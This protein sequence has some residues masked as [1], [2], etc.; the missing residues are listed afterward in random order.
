[1]ATVLADGQ[2][3]LDGAVLFG[4]G[5]AVRVQQVS[6]D[7]GSVA[8][9]DAAVV[10][11]DGIRMGVDTLPLLSLT[12]T[13]V[14]LAGAGNGGAALD[15]YETL[16]AAWM[17]EA[18]RAAPGAYSTLRIRY[19]GSAGV[20][21]VFGRGRRIAP[22]MGMVRQGVVPFTAQF[23]CAS[24]YFYQDGDSALILTM[25]PSDIAGVAN[26]HNRLANATF[27]TAVTG[28]QAV[29]CA[30]AWDGAT[31]RT[32][33]GA[34]RITPAG[35]TAG[36]Y[37]SGN[38]DNADL[39][40]TAR[41]YTWGAW[42]MA[43]SA[44]TVQVQAVIAWLNA[45]GAAAGTAAGPLTTLAPGT[46]TFLAASGVPAS[47][48]V[49]ADP[50]IA[51]AGSPAAT[52][53]MYA[54]DAAFIENLG[55]IAPPVTPPVVLGGTGETASTCAVPGTRRAWPVI[56]F[57][58]PVTNP[59]IAYPATGQWMRLVTALPA[60]VTATIDTRPWQR[61]VL[62]SDGASAAGA[63]RGSP[64]RDMALPPGL[65][66]VRFSGQDNTATARCTVT[67]RAP[68]GTIGGST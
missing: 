22:V 65:T 40:N 33:A 9:Q 1:M 36:V 66:P 31:F 8:S 20:R 46:W 30:A 39:I 11:G 63:L 67:W 10:Q 4:N 13:G 25:M 57:T 3:E 37:A 34:L 5:T 17:N 50:R 59:Q 49:T 48:A 2:W 18:V 54:D 35:S 12:V 45:G 62:R 6:W 38:L 47:A 64:P 43:P 60:G 68:S 15:T 26:L 52:D 44:L 21:A 61:T 19:P 55:G 24:P 53:V 16:A 23:D 42:V 29:N 56:T 27:D 14:V 58:G 41:A 7:G 32:A 28:W 51:Y